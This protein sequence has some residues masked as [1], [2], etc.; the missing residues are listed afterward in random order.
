MTSNLKFQDYANFSFES[1]STPLFEINEKDI[2]QDKI[3]IATGHFS[4]VMPIDSQ[5]ILKINKCLEVERET[6]EIKLLKDKYYD[7][8]LVV[9]SKN[10]QKDREEVIRKLNF[11]SK[12]RLESYKLLK[13]YLKDQVTEYYSSKVIDVPRRS[14]EKRLL[15]NLKNFD[16]ESLP[17][18]ELTLVEYWER[19][20]MESEFKKMTYKEVQNSFMEKDIKEKAQKLLDFIENDLNKNASKTFWQGDKWQVRLQTDRA[21]GQKK[22]MAYFDP[23]LFK[24]HATWNLSI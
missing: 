14:I 1:K 2:L 8:L 9:K 13:S 10:S 23:T 3:D 7:N 21:H 17:I 15:E 19:I 6:G 16:F 20:P 4:V 24:S 18:T 12:V 5:R 22:L 11:L